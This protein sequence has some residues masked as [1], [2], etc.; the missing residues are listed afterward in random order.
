MC[1]CATVKPGTNE[2]PWQITAT[3]KRRPCAGMNTVTGLPF[4][5]TRPACGKRVPARILI[6]LG[7]QPLTEFVAGRLCGAVVH[8][9]R[10]ADELAA[11]SVAGDCVER[12]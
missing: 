6:R 7:H 9:A 11:R 5:R 10:R 1:F 12:R 3:P 8:A 2:R 4:Q